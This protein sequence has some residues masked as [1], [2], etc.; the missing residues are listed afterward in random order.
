MLECLHG[1]NDLRIAASHRG[2]AEVTMGCNP[3][4]INTY[5]LQHVL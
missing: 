1:F 5:K 3:K 4:V 2:E